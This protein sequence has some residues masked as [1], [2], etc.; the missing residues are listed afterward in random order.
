[1]GYSL[2]AI[3]LCS[4]LLGCANV[5]GQNFCRGACID[6][7][8]KE[9]CGNARCVAGFSTDEEL[10]G[11]CSKEC[12]EAINGGELLKCL[13]AENPDRDDIS[14]AQNQISALINSLC[15]SRQ[16]HGFQQ[17][18]TSANSDEK[19]P[20]SKKGSDS[21]EAGELE[22]D[23]MDIF[24]S[25]GPAEEPGAYLEEELFGDYF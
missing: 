18:P 14:R 10:V 21:D 13:E 4:L 1:M 23:P 22:M 24:P 25:T 5:R 8:Y 17:E 2:L 19:G 20:S 12:S 11:L 7:L 3:V 16:L 6:R 15:L 9:S